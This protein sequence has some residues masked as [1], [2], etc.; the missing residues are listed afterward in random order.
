MAKPERQKVT[1]TLP[2][3]VVRGYRL[4]AARRGVHDQTVV[5]EALR[6][7]LGIDALERLR[8]AFAHLRLEPE[9]AE[10]LAVEEVRAARREGAVGGAESP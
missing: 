6:E 9:E 2:A 3:E 4:E 5:E 1:L 10:R 7:H 8:A